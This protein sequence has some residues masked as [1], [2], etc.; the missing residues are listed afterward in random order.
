[1]SKRSD[2]IFTRA[3]SSLLLEQSSGRVSIVPKLI[4]PLAKCE[5]VARPEAHEYINVDTHIKGDN[6][7]FNPLPGCFRANRRIHVASQ[8][9]VQTISGQLVIPKGVAHSLRAT[10]NNFPQ[11]NHKLQIYLDVMKTFKILSSKL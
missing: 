4:L 5:R 3:E 9:R 7:G 1:M 6:S 11:I 2:R 10:R 8:W